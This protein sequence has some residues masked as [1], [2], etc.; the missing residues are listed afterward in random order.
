MEAMGTLS[1]GAI[2]VKRYQSGFTVANAG[3]PLLG[4]GTAAA[5]ATGASVQTPTTSTALTT[6][7]V[8]LSLDTSGTVAAT[9]VSDNNDILVSVAVNP[10]LI[11]RCKMSNG[12]TEDTALAIQTTTAADSTGATA[13]GVTSL[14]QGMLWGYDGNQKGVMRRTDDTAGSVV[15]NFDDTT[16]I[17]SGDRFLFANSAPAV[18]VAAGLANG[19]NLSTLFTQGD[20]STANPGDNDTFMVLD[21]ELGT[22]D[23]D[24]ANN[25]FWHFVQNQNIFGSTQTSA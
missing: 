23:N 3:I 25:S 6:G 2:V 18:S 24:G 8:G 19:P 7:M 21:V 13:T 17:A 11:I 12:T 10:D 5:L 15:I 16:G 22:E 9:G 14:T 4:A 20:A 1:G